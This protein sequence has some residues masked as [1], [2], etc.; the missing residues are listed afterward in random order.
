MHIRGSIQF[1][2][3]WIALL[4]CS[5]TLRAQSDSSVVSSTLISEMSRDNKHEMLRCPIHQKNMSINTQFSLHNWPSNA[6]DNYPFSMFNHLRRYCLP[7][8]RK[9]RK[10][11]QQTSK[12]KLINDNN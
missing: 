6:S 4:T 2:F 3:I 5:I 12:Q 8:S 7:C 11:I 1:G 9:H 10:T